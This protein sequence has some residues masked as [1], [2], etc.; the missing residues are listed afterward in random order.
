MN[1][2]I[3]EKSRCQCHVIISNQSS[4]DSKTSTLFGSI[5]KDL[6]I[7]QLRQKTS[8]RMRAFIL[9]FSSGHECNEKLGIQP[10]TLINSTLSLQPVNQEVT[11]TN[12]PLRFLHFSLTFKTPCFL[13]A[14][15]LGFPH[16]AIYCLTRNKCKKIDVGMFFYNNQDPTSKLQ[17]LLIDKTSSSI[18][19][20]VYAPPL[21]V[22]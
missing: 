10:R 2:K 9:G 11:I 1:N 15:V 7:L 16:S 19:E 8:H 14:D 13:K 21:S 12:F 20:I 22:V 17:L 18:L 5:L 4:R 3:T 6:L